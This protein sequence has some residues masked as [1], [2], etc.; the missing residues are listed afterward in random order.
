MK[1]KKMLQLDFENRLCRLNPVEYKAHRSH[2]ILVRI[3]S[4]A[5]PDISQGCS[6]FLSELIFTERRKYEI[7]TID[8]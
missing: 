5:G 3:I 1:Y 8:C 2:R 4:D 7:I 6:I